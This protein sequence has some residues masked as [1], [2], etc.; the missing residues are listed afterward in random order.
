MHVSKY[1]G[2]MTGIRQ[3]FGI[4]TLPPT[5]ILYF[6]M[7]CITFYSRASYD[8]LLKTFSQWYDKIG[9]LAGKTYP[10]VAKMQKQ[11]EKIY[12]ELMKVKAKLASGSK[13]K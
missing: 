3:F 8:N 12:K 7:Y 13:K 1:F 10:R 6:S 11:T 5:Y 2:F 4:V 9:T